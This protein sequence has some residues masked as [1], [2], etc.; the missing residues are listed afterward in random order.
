MIISRKR[1][2]KELAEAE[3][4]AIVRMHDEARLEKLTED[5]WRLRDDVN[6]ILRRL[7]D[8]EQSQTPFNPEQNIAVPVYGCPTW[9]AD[10][11]TIT[12]TDTKTCN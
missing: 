3:N 10:D 7:D 2:E 4:R 6:C 1:F 9:K 5:L 12:C 8:L 11:I